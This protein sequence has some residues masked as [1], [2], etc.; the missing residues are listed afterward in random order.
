MEK[1]LFL[2]NNFKRYSE[3]NKPKIVIFQGSPRSKESCAGMVSKSQKVIDYATEIWSRFFDF[4][5]VDLAVGDIVIRPCKG[6]VSTSNGFHC[7]WKC[8]CY[9]KGMKIPDLVYEKRIYDLL[10]ECDGFLVVSPVNWYSVSTEVKALFDRLVCANLTLTKEDAEEIFGKKNI[11]NPEITGNAELSGKYKHLLKNH[12]EGKV[13]S[14]Y[15]H[16][17]DGASDYPEGQPETGENEWE[18]IN[19]ILPIVYQCRYSKIDAPNE[20]I[21]AFNINKGQPYYLANL[22]MQYEGEFFE[23]MDNLLDRLLYYINSKKSK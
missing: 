22:I 8:T 21:E 12:L 5:V 19:S 23:R 14:F 13:A 20:L 2:F 4:T 7:H 3:S 9:E 10:E 11:K 18:P 6:C 16:G 1:D 17:D 15:I